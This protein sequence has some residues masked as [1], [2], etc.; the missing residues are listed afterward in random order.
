MNLDQDR[1]P[2]NLD[3]AITLLE[4]ALTDLEKGAWTNMVAARMFQLQERI[5]RALRKDWSI[6]DANTPLRVYFRNLGLDDPEEVSMLLIDAYWRKFNKKS[7]PVE[8]LVREYLE[9]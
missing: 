8:E 3:E 9:G 2:A 6:D 5:A 7:L 1:V 4:S